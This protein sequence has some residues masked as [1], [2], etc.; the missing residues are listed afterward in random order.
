MARQD[1]PE[2]FITAS[3]IF[4]QVPLLRTKQEELKFGM[5]VPALANCAEPRVLCCRLSLSRATC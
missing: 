2:L 4:V 5:K 1:L 3:R